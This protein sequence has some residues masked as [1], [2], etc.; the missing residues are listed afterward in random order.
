MRSDL[1]RVAESILE[2]SLR[3]VATATHFCA[4]APRR[5]TLGSAQRPFDDVGYVARQAGLT[6]DAAERSFRLGTP[7]RFH[8]APA[9]ERGCH[10]RGDLRIL[11]VERQDDVGDE[12][13]AFAIGAIELRRIA[14]REGA[15]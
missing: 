14:V 2:K 6:L 8:C 5:G 11:R 9:P 4:I 13:I 10:A 3:T 12:V 7:F 15:D 1:S